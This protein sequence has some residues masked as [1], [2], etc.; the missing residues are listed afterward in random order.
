[1]AA[2]H[3]CAYCE[4]VADS[5]MS[6]PRPR[7]VIKIGSIADHSGPY[8]DNTGP[9]GV[10]CAKLAAQEFNNMGFDVEVLTGDS[11]NKPDLAASIVRKWFDQ[12]GVDMVFDG[13]ASSAAL[14]VNTVCR[15]KDKV[16]RKSTRLNS[17]HTDISRMPSSA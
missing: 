17:S 16:D 8:R 4:V 13:S 11:Q 6:R 14:A 3:N 5:D 9:T 7:P 15:E 10:A 2:A 1:M 12:D